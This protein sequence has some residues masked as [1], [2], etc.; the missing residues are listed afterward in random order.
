MSLFQ[1]AVCG[2]A[3]NSA[4]G[5]T[6]DTPTRFFNWSYAPERKGLNLCSACAPSLFSDGTPTPYGKWHNEFEQVFLP[7]GE[8]K[9][10]DKG[11]LA[12]VDNGDTN[13]RAYALN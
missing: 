8:F 11:N 5:V 6:E 12:H 10:N 2:C 3:E 9:T 7:L 13:F 4:L 1:C